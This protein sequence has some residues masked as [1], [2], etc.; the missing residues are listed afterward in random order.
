VILAAGIIWRFARSAAAPQFEAMYDSPIP[1]GLRW[2]EAPLHHCIKEQFHGGLL[3]V[4]GV[5]FHND[6]GSGTGKPGFDQVCE[7]LTA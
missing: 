7:A 1:L 3:L 2:A 5:V 6:M 4:F